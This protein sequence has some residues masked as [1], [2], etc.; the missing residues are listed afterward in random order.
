V[1]HTP[2]HSPGAVCFY[3]PE[4]GVLFSGDT[5]FRSSIGRHDLPGGSLEELK[6][7]I[8]KLAQL[9]PWNC[10]CPATWAWWPEKSGC[11][12]TSAWSKLSSFNSKKVDKVAGPG[13]IIRI[14]NQVDK[15]DVPGTE[16]K[17]GRVSNCF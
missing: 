11:R 1:I 14:F 4:P 16:G 13:A 7:S 5:V 12:K 17:A 6:A 2:G 9:D 3:L 8:D 15:V 10:S